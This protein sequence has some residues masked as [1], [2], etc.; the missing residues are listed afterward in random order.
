MSNSNEF[1]GEGTP[2]WINEHE[3]AM[4][5]KLDRHVAHSQERFDA[6]LDKTSEVIGK[7][8]SFVKKHTPEGI[9]NRVQDLTDRAQAALDTDGDTDSDS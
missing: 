3:T 9:G 5:E 6:A 7:A 2:R 8:G 1:T 4:R